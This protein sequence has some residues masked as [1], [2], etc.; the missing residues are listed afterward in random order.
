MSLLRGAEHAF[1][2][3]LILCRELAMTVNIPVQKRDATCR[4]VASV[5]SLV[6]QDGGMAT[7]APIIMMM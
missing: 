5:E 1:S 2:S 4:I 3:N 7:V 6:T